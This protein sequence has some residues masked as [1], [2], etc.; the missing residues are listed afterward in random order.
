[1]ISNCVFTLLLTSSVLG[2]FPVD[3]EA[4]A[5]YKKISLKEKLSSPINTLHTLCFAVDAYPIIPSLI[6]DGV[7]C[8]EIEPGS[9]DPDIVNTLVL[10][11]EEILDEISVPFYNLITVPN[12]DKITVYKDD[13]FNISLRKCEDGLWRFDKETVSRIK[14][15]RILSSVREKA[16]L[17][18]QEQYKTGLGNPTDTMTEFMEHAY[19]NDFQ[20]AM[21]HLDLSELSSEKISSQGPLI[22]W[23]L[24]A[25][26]QRKGYLFSQEIPLDATGPKFIWRAGA[27]GRISINRISKPGKKHIWVFDKD[28]IRSVD[29]MW[30]EV[31]N[32][33]IAI[34]YQIMGKTIAPVPEK[35]ASS[36]SLMKDGKPDLVPLELST[37]RKALRYFFLAIMESEFDVLAMQGLNSFLDLSSIPPE[38]IKVLGP[39]KAIMLE[40]ILRKINPDSNNISDSWSSEN[41]VISGSNG[42][43]IE[44][45]RQKDGCWRF[46]P[47]TVANV[48][49]MFVR[50]SSEEQA[51]YNYAHNLAN[52]R[53]SIFYFLSAVNSFKNDEAVNCM[54]LA[55]IPIPSRADLGPVLAFKLKFI[56]DRISLIYIPEIPTDPKL[57]AYEL[58]R[59]TLGNITLTPREGDKG[60]IEWKFDSSSVRNIERIFNEV[61]NFP[62]R[63]EY[64]KLKYIRLAPDFWTEPGIWIR[65]NTPEKYYRPFLG[66]CLYQ[67]VVGFLL[68]LISLIISFSLSSGVKKLIHYFFPKSDEVQFKKRLRRNFRALKVLLLFLLIYN[69]L[70]WVDLPVKYA[71]YIYT[72]EKVIITLVLAFFGMQMID[73][74][75]L[76]YEISETMTK[77]KGM[78]DMLVP[79]LSKSA[80]LIIVISAICL[81]ISHFGESESLGR[82]LAGLGIIGIAISLAAQD[83]LKNLFGTLLLISEKSFR[84]GDRIVLGDKEGIVEEF[85]FRSTKLRTAEDS[86]LLMPNGNLATAIIDNFGLRKHRRIRLAFGI[87]LHTEV[88]KIGK[89]QTMMLDKVILVPTVIKNKTQISFYKIGENGLE[90][91]LITFANIHND[92]QEIEM[93]EKILEIMLI[94]ALELD[95]KTTNLKK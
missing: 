61:V 66:I 38:D 74:I 12:Q 47:E 4:L 46:S 13:A 10:E 92:Y 87:D 89:L 64:E 1:M 22:A 11:L 19:N 25:I 83:S 94:V 39:K 58:Y 17:K 24:A 70:P 93:R 29:A 15:M 37:P 6:S 68:I 51:K 54:D 59:G 80:K 16:R 76:L 71:I 36:L 95:V 52:P 18:I 26:I 14:S 44:I 7:A 30:E 50:L 77:Y 73:T 67:W 72:V 27:D 34:L 42:F 49:S 21:H 2:F 56:F 90:F 65:L 48:P 55:E 32:K 41:Q 28:T 82:F 40:A 33:P 78:G 43:E 53:N 35:F 57:I 84:V 81:L 63:K 85:G 86:I 75:A 79:F 20:T 5:Q 31:K 88:E 45:V 23:K 8:L 60:K 62:T 9:I 91:E 69:L 3:E